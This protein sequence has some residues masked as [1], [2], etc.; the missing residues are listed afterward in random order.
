MGQPTSTNV[1]WATGK[2]CLG[3]VALARSAER[4]R[5]ATVGEAISL[6]AKSGDACSL[7]HGRTKLN[8]ICVPSAAEL[9]VL[10]LPCSNLECTARFNG[11]HLLACP[12]VQAV[13][14]LRA[15]LVVQTAVQHR[16][17]LLCGALRV[18]TQ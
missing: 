11:S 17:S 16:T 18:G 14:Y 4:L 10:R 1:M 3:N 8:V 5:V 15:G 9:K 7:K 13:K 12:V 6:A 2:R